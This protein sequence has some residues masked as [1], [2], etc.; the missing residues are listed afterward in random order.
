MS[1]QIHLR[2]GAAGINGFIKRTDG[3]HRCKPYATIPHRLA[4]RTLN[5]PRNSRS[6]AIILVKRT[7]LEIDKD[8]AAL[9]Q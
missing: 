8:I 9:R 4:E 7:S 2:I 1:E 6:R 3:T 5:K